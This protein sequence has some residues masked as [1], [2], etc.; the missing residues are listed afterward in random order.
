MDPGVRWAASEIAN[1]EFLGL[2]EVDHYAAH[3]RQDEVVLDAV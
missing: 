3:M 2:A 1:A